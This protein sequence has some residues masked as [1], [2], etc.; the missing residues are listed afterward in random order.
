MDIN[1]KNIEV[2][3]NPEAG[4]FEAQIGEHL[5]VMEYFPTGQSLVFTHTGV[6]NEIAGQGIASKMAQFALDYARAENLTVV[7]N[8]PFVSSYIRRHPEYQDLLP[9]DN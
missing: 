8:C 7:P 9:R 5:A 6:P 3:N 1:D 2:K 4:R